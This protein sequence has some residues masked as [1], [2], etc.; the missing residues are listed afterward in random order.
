QDC[1]MEAV[2]FKGLMGN[3]LVDLRLDLGG[4]RNRIRSTID[5]K[6]MNS[7]CALDIQTFPGEIRQVRIVHIDQLLTVP[8]L[9]FHNYAA[10]QSLK[11]E[12]ASMASAAGSAMMVIDSITSLTSFQKPLR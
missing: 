12:P 7:A 1:N 8:S 9:Y 6:M 10:L 5:P 11:S 3:F 4:R 2:Y